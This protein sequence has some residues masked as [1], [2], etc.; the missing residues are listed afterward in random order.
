MGS[1]P[2]DRLL[3]DRFRT[4]GEQL[5]EALFAEAAGEAGVTAV[6]LLVALHAG[7]DE[8]SRR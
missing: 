5:D 6:K 2:L 3:D 7:E 1:M 4:A 8:S